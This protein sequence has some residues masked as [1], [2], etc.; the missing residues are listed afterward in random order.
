VFQDTEAL[1]SVL[2]IEGVAKSLVERGPLHDAKLA[3]H[4]V[5]NDRHWDS[6]E[7]VARDDARLG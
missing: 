7:A 4:L 6:H 3:H 1:K 2:D 5:V